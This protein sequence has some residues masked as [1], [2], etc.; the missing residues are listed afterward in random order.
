ME[1]LEIMHGRSK[2]FKV[3]KK[4]RGPLELKRKTVG[5]KDLLLLK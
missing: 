4:S 3:E 2:K 1:N 5:I